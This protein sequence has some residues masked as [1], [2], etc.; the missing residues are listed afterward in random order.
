MKK[1]LRKRLTV[2]ILLLVSTLFIINAVTDIFVSKQNFS[3]IVQEQSIDR[4]KSTAREATSIIKTFPENYV[5]VL[6]HL[7]EREAS[8]DDVLYAVVITAPNLQA[9]A[10]SDIEKL[11]K[12]YDDDY[13]KNAVNNGVSASMEF[14]ADV[15]DTM[16]TDVIVPIYDTDGQLFGGL[17]IGLCPD[18]SVRGFITR[19]ILVQLIRMVIAIAVILVVVAIALKRSLAPIN[20][21]VIAAH[22]IMHGKLDIKMDIKSQDELGMLSHDFVEMAD[23]LKALIADISYCLSSMAKGDFTIYSGCSEKYTGDFQTILNSMKE[24]KGNLTHTLAELHASANQVNMGS[25]QI[26]SAAQGMAQGATEQAASVEELSATMQTISEKVA[27]NA[28]N[29]KIASQLSQEAGSDV[30]QSNQHMQELISAMDEISSSSKEISKVIKIID[31]IAFQTNILALNAAVE[32]ARAG[33]AGKGFAVVADEVRNLAAKSAEAVKSTSELIENTIQ[34]I[35]KGTDITAQTAQALESV[36]EKT[37]TVETKV[38]EMAS[39]SE[40]QANS[41]AQ[42]MDGMEQISA[43]VQNNSAT[44][45]ESAATSEE[46]S[47]QATMLNALVERFRYDEQQDNVHTDTLHEKECVPNEYNYQTG[48]GK[49]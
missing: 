14:Y 17:D 25:A 7:V 21:L 16:A 46:L 49:Y 38:Q 33:T 11:N 3:N 9:I 31:D 41:I 48:S 18:E 26:S 28:D 1:S 39:A 6:Q 15:Q 34:A 45:E 35:Q 13:T 36:V 4:V 23:N 32:A 44:A 12:F 19:A 22:E 20:Q 37:G 2:Y 8:L 47:G 5:E 40:E 10:H 27:Q 43:V 24:I 29:A 42:V 30:I